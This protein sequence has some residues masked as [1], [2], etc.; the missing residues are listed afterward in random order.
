[1]TIRTILL[2]I[3]MAVAGT[4][5]AAAQDTH[6]AAQ[7]GATQNDVEMGGGMMQR[8][9]G[10]MGR[11]MI[12][13]TT[14][15]A[16]SAQDDS[17]ASDED[18]ET[19]GAGMMEAH[20][21]RGMMDGRMGGGMMNRHMGRGMTTGAGMMQ[22]GWTDC[23]REAGMMR[24]GMRDGMMGRHMG[25][26]MMGRGMMGGRMMGYGMTGRARTGMASLFGMRVRPVMSL[27]VDDVR[28]YL[29]LRL[30]RLG[31]KRLKLGD[32]KETDGDT[33][34]ADIVTV[35]NSLVQQL[36]VDRHTGA[37]TYQD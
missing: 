4:L 8:G 15:P 14:A 17:V 12:P 19:E 26:R 34:T 6:P 3:A 7:S 35:D 21:D 2:T 23:G 37:I 30:N 16:G 5:G 25:Q 28:A 27:S 31:N 32:T 18:S 10:T 20:M 11:Q 33:I 24:D 1:M 36:K 29:Q 22:D 9:N 13:A